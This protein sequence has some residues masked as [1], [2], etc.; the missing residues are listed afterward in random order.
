MSEKEKDRVLRAIAWGC[1]AANRSG[2]DCT[3]YF[4]AFCLVWRM[5]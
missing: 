3:I 1:S 2:E 4:E 5:K